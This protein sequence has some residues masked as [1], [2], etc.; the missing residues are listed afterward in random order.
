MLM[1]MAIYLIGG[2][3]FGFAARHVSESRGEPDGFWW[4]FWLGWLGLLIV[5]FRKTA[6]PESVS[7]PGRKWRCVKCGT[8]NSEGRES[9]QTCGAACNT[10][11]PTKVCVSCGARNKAVN[12]NCFACGHC[13]EN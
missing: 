9:C 11:N 1:G 5:I 8:Y 3:L 12:T 6:Q 10:P 7:A 4:G 2:L 13:F